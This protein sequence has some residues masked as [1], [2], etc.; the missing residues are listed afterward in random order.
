MHDSRNF[1]SAPLDA[2]GMEKKYGI[3]IYERVKEN[4]VQN[5]K[6]EIQLKYLALIKR[7]AESGNLK[8]KLKVNTL[9]SCV[10]KC[11]RHFQQ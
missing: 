10:K 7:R 8:Y 11:K 1:V 4:Q 3:P 6:F 2:K 9:K 5:S